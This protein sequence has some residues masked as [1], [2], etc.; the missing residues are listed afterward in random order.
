MKK[1]IFFLLIIISNIAFSQSD[2]QKIILKDS[3]AFM[4]YFEQKNYDKIL[5]MSHPGLLEKF[6]K[7]MLIEGF[8]MV[9]EGNDEFKI[10]VN[11]VDKN[12]Y[13][14]SDI[15]TNK[16]GGK[17]AFITFPMSME[18]NFLK[19]K[20]DEERKKLMLDMLAAQGMEGTFIN[21]NTV[22]IKKTSMTVAINDKSTNNTW[23]YLNHDENNPLYIS[24]VPVDIIKQAKGYYSDI[25]IK[26][27][28][29]NAN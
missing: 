4:T 18:M 3:E 26:Q 10:K 27:K 12:L 15:F 2:E 20:I 29:E 1:L 24:I 11:P 28:E 7:K 22:S 6:D 25:L 16:N 9:F 14:V 21:D 13:Q 5:E 19:Q 23:K 17:Y 8:K